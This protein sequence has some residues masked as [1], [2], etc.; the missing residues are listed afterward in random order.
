MA[1]AA[2]WASVAR[3][4]GVSEEARWCDVMHRL[5]DRIEA[6]EKQDKKTDDKKDTA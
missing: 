6:V 3:R 1:E 5:L 2:T 4:L